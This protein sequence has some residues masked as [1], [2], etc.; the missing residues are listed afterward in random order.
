[1]RLDMGRVFGANV[2]ETSDETRDHPL[3]TTE[4][5]V[6]HFIDWTYFGYLAH[7]QI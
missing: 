4:N 5:L 1:M 7:S 3:P 6:I 2:I